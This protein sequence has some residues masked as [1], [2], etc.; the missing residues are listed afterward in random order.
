MNITDMITSLSEETIITGAIFVGAGIIYILRKF[1]F[2][3]QRISDYE[4]ADTMGR[5]SLERDL[6]KMNELIDGIRFEFE[7]TRGSV[8]EE[9]VQHELLGLNMA[10]RFQDLSKQITDTLDDQSDS[11]IDVNRNIDA[12]SSKVSS[13]SN[14]NEDNQ[15]E[16]FNSMIPKLVSQLEQVDNSVKQ[17]SNR[18]SALVHEVSMIKRAIGVE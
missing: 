13:I 3:N 1:S 12:I 9:L 5:E 4:L 18:V 15:F 14:S 17:E 16:Q 10:P 6:L 8:E 7:E 2:L 11:I